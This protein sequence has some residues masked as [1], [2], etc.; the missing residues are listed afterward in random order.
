MHTLSKSP[1]VVIIGAGIVGANL[2]DE[3][4]ACGWTDITVLDRGPIP[5]TGGSTSHAPGLVF[6]T[7]PSRA[8][9]RLAAY[10]R[11]KLASLMDP[12]TGEPAFNPVGGLEVAT[13]AERLAELHRRAN[14]A[15]A[16]GLEA[17]VLDPGP[18]AALHPLL[19]A[20]RILGALHVPTDG[21]ASS[22]LAVEALRARAEARGARFLERVTVTGLESDAG[23]VTGVRTS[24]AGGGDGA[25]GGARDGEVLAADVVVSAAGFWGPQIGELAGVRVPLVPLAH[26]YV[27]TSEVPALRRWR[28]R[29]GEASG[30]AGEG[31][32]VG[33]GNTARLPILRHQGEDLYFRQ[34]GTRLGIG[35][36]AHRPMPARIQDLPQYDA[37]TGAM[38]SKLPFTPADFEGPWAASRELLPDLR[39]TEVREG[40]NG[41]FS[42]TPDGGS[43]VGESSEL[44]GFFLAEAVWVTHSAG[45]ARAVAELIVNGGSETDLRELDIARFEEVQLAGD[46]VLETSQQAFVEVYDIKHPLEPRLSPRRLRLSPFYDRQVELGA[47]FLESGGW[48][49]PHWFEANRALLEKLPA[50]W[51]PPERAGWTGRYDSPVSAAEAY[52]T[53]TNVALFDLTSL[54]RL[55]VSGPGA[56]GLLEQLTTGRVD[57]AVG[58]VGYALML[59]EAG[60]IRSDVTVARV[61]Q[62]VF[63]VG[64]NGGIDAAYLARAAADWNAAAGTGSERGE[65]RV[66][67]LTDRTCCIGVWGPRARDLVQ[68]LTETDLSD[69]G[70]RYFRAAVTSVAGIEVRIL[71]VSYVGELGWEIY[72]DTAEGLEL[73]DALWSAGRAMGVVAAG[74]AAFN[75]LRIEKGYRAWGTD[76]DTEHDPWSAGLGFAVRKDRS[77]YVGEEAVDRLRGGAQAE[78][79]PGGPGAVANGRRRALRCLTVDDATTVVMG[80]DPVFVGE[81]AVGHT[82]SAAYGYTVHRPIAY[83]WLPASVGVGDAVAIRS[84]DRM[85]PATVTAE[86]LVDPD[87]KRL[88][89]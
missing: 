29:T 13:T 34:I 22:V 43:L 65:V 42:F 26:Q 67:D 78:A 81:E 47:S 20:G 10:T 41:I 89:G 75:S 25:G 7:N 23:R 38:P 61:G 50:E 85:V 86:P 14:F 9:T 63:Q 71:R 28:D 2:A 44:R 37:V 62:D 87:G 45:V 84:F 72:A 64:A 15:V 6:Q 49:R 33:T 4:T 76:M 66:E 35:S 52:A 48:E 56:V 51:V 18:A 74:R 12:G 83:A 16:W 46:Y 58:S 5:L 17:T 55:E 59:T 3:L 36:Y 11:T 77:G 39:E 40:F 88:R 54:R 82:T 30:R 69:D 60:G 8:M 70:L 68:L 53:R 80:S 21:L 32:A 73:W 57:R 1:R 27:T 79:S 19:H 31:A 24:G